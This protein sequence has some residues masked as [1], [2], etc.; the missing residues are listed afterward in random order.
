MFLLD[1]NVISELRKAQRGD[2]R[3]R[4][5]ASAMSLGSLHVSVISMM[6]LE[7]GVLRIERR[8]PAQ[9]ALLRR[10]LENKVVEQFANRTLPIDAAIAKRCAK[11]HA[12]DPRPERDAFIAATALEHGLTIVTR[13]TA[14]FSSM[15][16]SMFNPW[17]EQ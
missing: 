4:A 1:T 10:W 7:V 13:N 11:L 17:L 6:E 14:D 3:V 2:A 5:W 12:P 16:V 9:G 8:D 15:G